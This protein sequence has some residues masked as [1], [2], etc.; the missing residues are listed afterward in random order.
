MENSK[1]YFWA[2]QLPDD[3]KQSIQDKLQS[4]KQNFAFKRW[5]HKSDYHITL[6]F[7]G[8]MD[9]QKQH[10]IIN[11]VGN[12]IKEEK[13]FNLTIQ[14]IN[15]FGNPK[16]PRI[17]WGAVQHEDALFKLQSII[18]QSC[19]DAGFILDSRPYNPHITLAKRWGGDQEFN[20]AFLEKNN[21]FHDNSLS[22]IADRIVLYQTNLDKEPKYEPVKTFM[23]RS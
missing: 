7:L 5:V 17:F 12:S 18:Q 9:E 14:G 11:L 8:A 21:P 6:A 19:C 1:H 4:L 20:S 3:I 15:I 23:L 13:A 22:F 10:T 16:S 2:V